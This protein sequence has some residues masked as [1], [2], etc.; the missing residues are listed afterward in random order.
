MDSSEITVC[1][2]AKCDKCGKW[3]NHCVS[4]TKEQWSSILARLV[5]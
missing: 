2:R 3:T 4:F 1:Q 5:K